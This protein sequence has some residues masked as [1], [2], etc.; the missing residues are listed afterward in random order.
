MPVRPCAQPGLVSHP[1]TLRAAQLRPASRPAPLRRDARGFTLVEACVTLAVLALLVG[2][3]MPSLQQLLHTRRLDAAAVQLATDLQFARSQALARNQPVRLHF[4][5]GPGTRS[6]YVI[7][8]AGAATCACPAP[9]ESCPGSLK[10][11]SLGEGDAVTVHAPADSL[12]FDPRHGTSTPT[13][14]LRLNGP[15][16]RSVHQVVNVMGRVRSCSPQARVP[17]YPAC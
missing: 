13:G 2:A 11:V 15:D 10:T 4:S 5:T 6:C 16:G 1:R 8:P 7:R 12:L 14:T 17:G 9:G 3:A